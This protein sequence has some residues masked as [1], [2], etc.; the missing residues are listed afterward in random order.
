[1]SVGVTSLRVTATLKDASGVAVDGLEGNTTIL[2][3]SCWANFTDLAIG[4]SG[5]STSRTH[6]PRVA[7]RRTGSNR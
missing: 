3:R 2:F 7:L 6:N 5:T 4:I 1:V